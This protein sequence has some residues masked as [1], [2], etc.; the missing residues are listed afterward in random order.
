AFAPRQNLV[1]DGALSLVGSATLEDIAARLSPENPPPALELAAR[2]RC[3]LVVDTSRP[4]LEDSWQGQRLTL[5]AGRG[6]PAELQGLTLLAGGG[7]GRC[8]V[9]DYQPETGERTARLLKLLASYRP[10]N[11]RGEPTAGIYVQPKG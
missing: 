6:T 8:A 9:I 5:Q 7:I 11:H 4:Y 2:L 10:V 1:F 3:N